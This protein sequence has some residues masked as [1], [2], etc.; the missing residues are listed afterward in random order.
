MP[1]VSGAHHGE[2]SSGPH[3][4]SVKTHWS[5]GHEQNRRVFPV[6]MGDLHNRVVR[7]Q[8]FEDV[9]MNIYKV[10]ELIQ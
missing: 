3:H 5:A 2:T 8:P 7:L 4:G 6:P 9:A 1:A 10:R